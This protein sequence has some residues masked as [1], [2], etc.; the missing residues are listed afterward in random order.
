M[1]FKAYWKTKKEIFGL[2]Y[3]E[4]FFALRE[5]QLSMFLKMDPGIENIKYERIAGI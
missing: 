5:I 1:A 3:Q 4:D 2:D